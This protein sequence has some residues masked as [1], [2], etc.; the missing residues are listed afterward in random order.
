MKGTRL[1]TITD[2]HGFFKLSLSQISE[3]DTLQVSMIGYETVG[4]V[5]SGQK[6][7]EIPLRPGVE[8]EA[9]EVETQRATTSISL[10]DPLNVQQ[11]NKKELA[12]AA[13]CNESSI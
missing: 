13:C 11:I 1:G 10:L 9:A 12:K 7:V 8:I 3:G 6:Y 5:Y 2:L 4:L